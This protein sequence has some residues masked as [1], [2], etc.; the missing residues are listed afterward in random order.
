MPKSLPERVDPFK[1]ASSGE[2]LVGQILV[3]RMRRLGANG[4][5]AL[6]EVGIDLNFFEDDAGKP[7]IRGHV[8]V[9][10]EVQCQRCLHPMSLAVRAEVR[11]ALVHSAEEEV[12]AGYELIEIGDEPVSLIEM[13]E[14]ELI[15]ALPTTPRHPYGECAVMEEYYAETSL[16]S[17]GSPFR[18]LSELKHRS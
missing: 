3:E 1:L 10:L 6:G 18:V 11:L 12:E 15:L 5:N 8:D 17:P 7:R 9:A 16:E 13:V 14:D 2:R 4:V